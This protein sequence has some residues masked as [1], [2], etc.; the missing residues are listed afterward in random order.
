MT[1]LGVT[2]WERWLTL[3][4]HDLSVGA[5]PRKPVHAKH[6]VDTSETEMN[7]HAPLT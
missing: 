5:L 2:R 1:A 4:C 6:E 3:E 7:T